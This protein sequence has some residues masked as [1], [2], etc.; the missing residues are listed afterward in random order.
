MTFESPNAIDAGEAPPTR[1]GRS[2]R[3][4][5]RNH[6]IANRNQCGVG[7]G[8][9]KYPREV[10]KGERRFRGT[11]I[12]IGTGDT[13]CHSS[14]SSNSLVDDDD[15]ETATLTVKMKNCQRNVSDNNVGQSSRYS[16]NA[17]VDDDLDGS[18]MVE[19]YD[20][21][22]EGSV[23][24]SNHD[25]LPSADEARMYATSLLTNSFH[26]NDSPCYGDGL[27]RPLSS[28]PLNTWR[29]PSRRRKARNSPTLTEAKERKSW[30]YLC[31]FLV[32]I[33]V[34]LISAVLF[35]VFV[36]KAATKKDQSAAATSSDG[37]ASSPASLIAGMVP[38]PR[39]LKTIDWLEKHNISDMAAL[40]TAGSSQFQA[41]QWIADMDTEQKEVPST[42][43]NNSLRIAVNVS[44]AQQRESNERFLQRYILAVLFFEWK[45]PQWKHDLNFLSSSHECGWF[46]Y[47]A[48]QDGSKYAIGVTCDDKLLVSDIFIPN[49]HLQGSSIPKEISFLRHLEL[50]SLRR[51]NISGPV[52]TQDLASLSATLRYLDI[53][54]CALTGTMPADI[55]N[56]KH[57]KVLG[58]SNNQ[59]TGTIASSIANLT[60]L[61]TLDLERN[62]FTGHVKTTLRGLTQ[63]EYLYLA[64]NE[65][66]DMLD[67][68]FLFHLANIKGLTLNNNKFHTLVQLPESLFTSHPNMTVLDLSENYL[69]GTLPA[70][71]TRGVTVESQLRFLS[72]SNNQ[73]SGTLPLRIQALSNLETLDL[74]RNAFVG[75]VPVS[76]ANLKSLK[77]LKLG[78]NTFENGPIPPALFTISKIEEISMPNAHLT[79]EI[80]SWFPL[81]NQLEVLDVR[82]NQLTG[83]IPSEIWEMPALKT[84]LLSNNKL[85]STLPAS[86]PDS[87]LGRHT[88]LARSSFISFVV[89]RAHTLHHFLHPTL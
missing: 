3:G 58:L 24:D 7:G 1:P 43:P 63:L 26:D 80:P 42:A 2:R 70:M 67:D 22:E 28:A 89:L 61:I 12:Q 60:S 4:G 82:G 5:P 64:H 13:E 46:T 40:N 66:D 19:F 41:A 35:I 39:F 52:P 9:R 36:T 88:S 87:Q 11:K 47:E 27:V 17:A 53:S 44:V 48:A 68:S 37:N 59:L 55:G 79:G 81:F 57:L 8:I 72:F 56:F 45:G 65:L 25:R 54:E 38:S 51:N 15:E 23:V 29:R 75:P 78:H 20:G 62:N 16:T 32:A 14:D 84:L 30:Q 76:L 10:M 86:F 18:L 31:S 50:L 21:D 77:S 33:T 83:T 49:N 85:N 34:L 73:L 74:S 71:F 69:K 6:Q